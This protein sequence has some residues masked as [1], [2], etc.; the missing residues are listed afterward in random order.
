MF[1]CFHVFFERKVATC[2]SQMQPI[3][4]AH[5]MKMICAILGDGKWVMG[6]E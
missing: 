3:N 2:K 5:G 1:D 4:H 6:F